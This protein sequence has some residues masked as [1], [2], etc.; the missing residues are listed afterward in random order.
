[1]EDAMDTKA[2]VSNTVPAPTPEATPAPTPEA[3]PELT[4]T[5]TPIYTKVGTSRS[6]SLTGTSGADA[7]NGLAGSDRIWGK[8]GND[9]LVG[10]S[11]SDGFVFDTKL[12][13][14]SNVDTIMDFNVDGD[15]LRL[16]DAI[17]TKLSKG[18]LKSSQF[19]SGEKALDS[20]DY[21]IYDKNTGDVY[22]DRDGSGSSAAVKFA[23]IDNKAK[24]NYA[25]FY[26]F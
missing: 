4:P 10:G 2:P 21:I 23:D 22:Y 13:A 3:T 19:R 14:A 16:D 9:I 5:P 18:T 17:F 20:N 12:N 25:D 15:R 24:L 8:G 1:M 11:G 7:I 6:E 26:V